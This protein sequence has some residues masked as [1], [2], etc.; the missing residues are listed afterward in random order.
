MTLIALA[1]G[2]SLTRSNPH[3]EV[4]I[5]CQLDLYRCVTVSFSSERH[6]LFNQAASTPAGYHETVVLREIVF[7]LFAVRMG[8]W[9]A[10]FYLHRSV[11]SHVDPRF[12]T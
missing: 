12:L 3:F 1:V 6:C 2:G 9:R 4:F 8:H 7:T 10:T 11:L 5:S